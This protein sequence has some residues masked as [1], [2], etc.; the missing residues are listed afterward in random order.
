MQN[1]NLQLNPA[2]P[3]PQQGNAPNPAVLPRDYAIPAREMSRK[4]YTDSSVRWPS[5][6][7]RHVYV[8]FFFLHP[9][10]LS[11]YR[12]FDSKES[13]LQVFFYLS[14]GEWLVNVFY[15]QLV[16]IHFLIVFLNP[17]LLFIVYFI[18]WVRGQEVCIVVG[19]LL[20]Y[21]F[22]LLTSWK[23][24]EWIV[25]SA[26]PALAEDRRPLSHLPVPVARVDVQYFNCRRI[27]RNGQD[28]VSDT[29]HILGGKV[30]A[31]LLFHYAKPGP[32]PSLAIVLDWQRNQAG[33][34]VDP[35]FY[36]SLTSNY[37]Y[38]LDSINDMNDKYLRNGP[39]S[40]NLN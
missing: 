30:L 17:C 39:A 40:F 26:R 4:Y 28:T 34:N 16:G 8:L 24:V 38:L 19:F 2:L 31:E 18:R 22:C 21:T 7:A 9:L 25:E 15:F 6:L 13:A 35:L 1:N 36:E 33:Y 29:Y 14:L 10:F 20:D 32:I 23:T 5:L 37:L 12:L 3:A 27:V 11:K